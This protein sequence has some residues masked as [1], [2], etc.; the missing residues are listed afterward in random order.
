M[1]TFYLKKRSISKNISPLPKVLRG[2]L[3]SSIF[4]FHRMNTF[5]RQFFPAFLQTLQNRTS[6]QHCFTSRCSFSMSRRHRL[7]H[8]NG[9]FV[10]RWLEHRSWFVISC[11][12]SWL[13]VN[14]HLV[15][16]KLVQLLTNRRL[17]GRC[18]TCPGLI[19]TPI[20]ILYLVNFHI[21]VPVDQ[22]LAFD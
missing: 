4:V 14:L 5:K 15:L 8:K 20:I 3:S 19:S 11:V 13:F 6:T 1:Q 21:L 17:I 2:W 18:E 7:N 10:G 22:N 9:E 12:M 16:L